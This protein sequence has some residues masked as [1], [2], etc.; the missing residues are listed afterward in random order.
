MQREMNDV[1]EKRFEKNRML[2][3]LDVDSQVCNLQGSVESRAN[4][5]LVNSGDAP[6]SFVAVVKND[7]DTLD[8]LKT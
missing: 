4:V 5:T 2:N 1:E 8:S 3:T 6:S 7:S